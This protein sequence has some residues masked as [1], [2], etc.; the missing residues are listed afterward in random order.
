MSANEIQYGGDH[1]KKSSV[2]HWDFVYSDLGGDY[3][4]GCA[5]KYIFRFGK[6][7]D[8]ADAIQDLKKAIH[9]LQ[10]KVEVEEEDWIKAHQPLSSKKD[11]VAG[12]AGSSYVNQDPD[13]WG[14][15][16]ETND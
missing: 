9:Y 13:V 2:S 3:L 1:Y 4:L 10:K 12:E 14:K 5:T 7:G 6:K 8:R 11:W 16:R 15:N